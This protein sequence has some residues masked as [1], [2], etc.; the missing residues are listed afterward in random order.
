MENLHDLAVKS[1]QAHATAEVRLAS[2]ETAVLNMAKDH[3]ELMKHIADINKQLAVITVDHDHID[4]ALREDITAIEKGLKAL[5]DDHSPCSTLDQAAKE[6][7]ETHKELHRRITDVANYCKDC[8]ASGYKGLSDQVSKMDG[9]LNKLE[10][11]L[12]VFSY[13]IKDFPIW[14]LLIVM[15]LLNFSDYAARNID[16][17]LRMIK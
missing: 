4:K 3:K 11:N 12:A 6:N 2:L 1:I 10:K 8:P 17:I 5:A 15:I 13:K 7:K 14:L 9:T 16:W